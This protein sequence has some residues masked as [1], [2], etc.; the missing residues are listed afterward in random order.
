MRNF[1]K[2][3]NTRQDVINLLSL[4]PEETKAYLKRCIEGYKNFIP[5]SEHKSQKECIKDENHDYIQTESD[6][7]VKYIQREFKIVP[8]NDLDRLGITIEDAK[9]LLLNN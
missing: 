4:Y 6:G 8:G 9:Y 3:I 7:A 2:H 5:V 1:P